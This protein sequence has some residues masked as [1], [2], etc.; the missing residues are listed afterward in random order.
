MQPSN[1]LIFLIT[2]ALLVA[3]RVASAEP[4]RIGG[5]G[6][7]TEMM[8][9]LGGKFAAA[10]EVELEVI[11]SLGSTGGIRALEARMA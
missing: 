11:P 4:L 9:F 5:T 8:R 1:R 7:A 10:D 2:L 6:S 3:G